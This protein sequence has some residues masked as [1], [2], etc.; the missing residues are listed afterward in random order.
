MAPRPDHNKI[1]SGMSSVFL[2]RSV[3]RLRTL[4]EQTARRSSLT[5]SSIDYGHHEQIIGSNQGVGSLKDKFEQKIEH[6]TVAVR[7]DS[8]RGAEAKEELQRTIRMQEQSEIDKEKIFELKIGAPTYNYKTDKPKPKKLIKRIDNP[9]VAKFK[10]QGIKQ[11][12]QLAR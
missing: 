1:A 11:P 9:W 7:R 4:H 5:R 3:F 12:Q 8:L 2:K 6:Q 10:R